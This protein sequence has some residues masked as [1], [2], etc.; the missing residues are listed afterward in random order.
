[1]LAIVTAVILDATGYIGW[2]ILQNGKGASRTCW[3]QG[4]VTARDESPLVARNDLSQ[5]GYC[6]KTVGVNGRQRESWTPD[7]KLEGHNDNDKA[8]VLM[9]QNSNH[10]A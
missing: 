9:R 6:G 4:R 1:M 8:E 3:T 7:M 5:V 2:S 10:V